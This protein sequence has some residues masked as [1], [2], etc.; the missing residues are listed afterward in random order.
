MCDVQHYIKSCEAHYCKQKKPSRSHINI[1]ERLDFFCL[2]RW[3]GRGQAQNVSVSYANGKHTQMGSICQ[4]E[5]YARMMRRS[6]ALHLK[7]SK[8]DRHGRGSPLLLV[9]NRAKELSL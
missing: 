6:G 5:A 8:C 9:Y 7:G 4:W 1:C 3:A 2:L